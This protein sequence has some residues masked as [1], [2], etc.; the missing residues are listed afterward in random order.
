M[1]VMMNKVSFLLLVCCL[2]S[3][4]FED[5]ERRHDVRDEDENMVKQEILNITIAVHHLAN[6]V[7]AFFEPAKGQKEV[8]ID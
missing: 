4:A 5:I 1:D 2:L 7:S 8:T 6:I 3:Y